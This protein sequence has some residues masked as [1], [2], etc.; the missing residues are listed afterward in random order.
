MIKGSDGIG[1]IIVKYLI[2]LGPRKYNH[3]LFVCNYGTGGNFSNAPIFNS[4]KPC[5]KCPKGTTCKRGLC[6][7][8]KRDNERE[9][10]TPSE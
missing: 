6:S 5:S 2:I 7:K 10:E 3:G 9:L 4:G 8:A 1:L